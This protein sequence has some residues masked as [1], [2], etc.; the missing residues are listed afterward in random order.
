MNLKV[1]LVEDNGADVFLILRNLEKSGFVVCHFQ[2]DSAGDM[3]NALEN[4]EWDVIISDFNIPGF[5]GIEA[6]AL[7]KSMKKDIPF[8]L[9]S[10]TIGEEAAVSIMKDGANDYV[11]KNN[12]ARLPEAIKRELED[13]KIRSQKNKFKKQSEKLSKIIEFSKEIV[14]TFDKDERITYINKAGINAFQFEDVENESY[15]ISELMSFSTYEEFSLIILHEIKNIGYW[16]GELTFRSRNG[17]EIPMLLSIVMQNEKN[18]NEFSIIAIDIT[19]RKEHEKEIIELN[20]SLELQIRQRTEEL[21]R[22]YIQLENKNKEVSDSINYALRIQQAILHKESDLLSVFQKSFIFQLPRNIVSGDFFWSI[23]KNG[24]KYIAVIDCT[25]HGVPGAF[26]SIIGYRLINKAI[27]EFK[28]INP[29]GIL[30][31]LDIELLKTFKNT[32]SSENLINDGMDICICVIDE[33]SNKIFFSG[34]NRPML[35]LSEGQLQEIAGTNRAIGS[36]LMN[37]QNENFIQHEIDYTNGDR[38]YLFSDGYQS[39]FGGPKG[40]KANKKYLKEVILERK[41]AT[42]SQQGETVTESFFKWK[43]EYEQVDDICVIGIEL[44]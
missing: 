5:G 40:K 24:F 27:S 36:S 23:E 29:A 26:I 41:L 15:Y 19:E 33:K 11:M 21:L 16:D 17:S 12:L 6:L 20:E 13:F 43:K 4:E 2:V 9:V 10:G 30:E 18:D 25:G 14:L 1:L 34:A 8:I 44:E 38:I 3:K 7:L 39:Q 32:K 31:F 28:L 22:S 35:Y 42:I 37:N